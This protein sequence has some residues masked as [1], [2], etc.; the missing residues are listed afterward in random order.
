MASREA[1]TITRDMFHETFHRIAATDLSQIVHLGT[2]PGLEGS[3]SDSIRDM[4]LNGLHD[5]GCLRPRACPEG[6]SP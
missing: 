2:E 5:L 3:G 6:G 4:C 1:F